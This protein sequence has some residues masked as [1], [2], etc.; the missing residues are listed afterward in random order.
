MRLS[1]FGGRSGIKTPIP[2]GPAQIIQESFKEGPRPR[3]DQVL[4]IGFLIDG[5]N[6]LSLVYAERKV[7]IQNKDGFADLKKYESNDFHATLQTSPY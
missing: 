3:W 4:L 5:G 7:V 1:S 6:D 2:Y